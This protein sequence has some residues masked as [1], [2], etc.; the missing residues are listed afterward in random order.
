MAFSDEVTNFCD[1][2]VAPKIVD[3]ILQGNFA[4]FR[5]IGNGKKFRGTTNPIR[6][7][8][9]KSSQGGSYSGMGNFAMAVEANTVNLN[10]TP[11][12]YAQPVTVNNLDLAVN[13]NAK[14]ID[15]LKYRMESAQDD[16]IDDLG[17]IFYGS[18]SGNDPDGLKNIVDDGT[19]Q[20]TW[21][22]QSRTTYSTLNADVS[23]A[24]G[25]LTIDVMAA[26]IDAIS[27]GNQYPTVAITTKTVYS[28]I[29]R[30]LFPTLSSNVS[31]GTRGRLTRRGWM[32]GEGGLDGK[33]GFTAI[34]YRGIPIVADDKCTSGY[35]YWL[36]E[37]SLWWA[38][39]PHPVHG[40][41]NLGNS[42]INSVSD[43]PSGNHGICWTG[44]KEP[45]N[46]DGQTGQFLLYGQMIC[47]APRLNALD[48][49]I[50]S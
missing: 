16:M 15:Y 4:A 10:F 48:Y 26:S 22:G 36:N 19:V 39:L 5:F 44:L 49:G 1:Q 17:D 29:E 21:G 37:N 33:F 40:T 3:N 23:S 50:T 46:A 14:V 13:D 34:S 2:N 43:A 47:D 28:I 30:L 6:I 45:V 42:T 27:I 32:S 7:K 38:S 8:Y 41:V 18:G 35:L 20:S 9:Q 12:Q 24:V 25:E 11:K 31:L